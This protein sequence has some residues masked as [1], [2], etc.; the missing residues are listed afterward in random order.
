VQ[1]MGRHD[2]SG[3]FII[4]MLCQLVMRHGGGG[5]WQTETLNNRVRTH[6]AKRG[7]PLGVGMEF[8]CSGV[9][10]EVDCNTLFHPIF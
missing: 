1:Y 5:L 8:F 9:T 3:I 4:I 2:S 6:R 10:G 7:L